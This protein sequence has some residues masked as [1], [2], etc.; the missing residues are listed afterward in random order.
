MAEE[1]RNESEEKQ[2]EKNWE[3]KRRRDPLATLGWALVLIW[4]GIVLLA[5]NLDFIDR[6]GIDFISDLQP[7]S[8]VFA[9]AGI[10]VLALVVIR[11]LVPEYRG[12]VTGNI[13]FGFI[14]L[15]IG[16]GESVGWGIMGALILIAL[17]ISYLVG[18]FFKK[19]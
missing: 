14:L 18:G 2:D 1:R 6:I 19:S 5:D 13:I 4:A 10:I 17:G 8:L 15:G 9:G 12:P 7:W 3:E 16:L 11:L